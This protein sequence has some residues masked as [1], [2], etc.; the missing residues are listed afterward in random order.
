MREEQPTNTTNNIKKKHNLEVILNG[1]NEPLLRGQDPA[2]V[3][4]NLGVQTGPESCDSCP[5]CFI[6]WSL[7]VR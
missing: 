7:V 2:E 4:G 5:T 3:S 6:I 1:Q